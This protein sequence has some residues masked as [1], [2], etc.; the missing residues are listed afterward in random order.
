MFG[1]ICKTCTCVAKKNTNIVVTV[2]LPFV[3][4]NVMNGTVF[5]NRVYNN[6]VNLIKHT[7]L[8]ELVEGEPRYMRNM[9]RGTSLN[10]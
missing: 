3:W 6:G 8:L 4:S 1:T 9:W 7:L 5:I 10:T 2:L